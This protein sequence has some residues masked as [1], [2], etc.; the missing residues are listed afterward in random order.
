[1]HFNEPQHKYFK[2][3]IDEQNNFISAS[4]IV[5]LYETPYDSFYWSLYKAYEFLAWRELKGEHLTITDYLEKKPQEV[6]DYFRQYRISFK[7]KDYALFDHLR[8]YIDEN[9]A[10]KVQNYILKVWK[11]INKVSIIKGN[12]LHD[13]KEAEAL[14]LD[15]VTNPFTGNSIPVIKCNKWITSDTKV[16]TV[17]L[18]NLADGYYAELILDHDYKLGQSDKIWKEGNFFWIDDWKTNK[19]LNF[20]NGF[21]RMQYPVDHL[22]DCNWEHYKLQLSYYIHILEQYGY[23]CK[24]SRLTHCIY[25]E[26]TNIWTYKKYDFQHYTKEIANIL[27]DIEFKRYTNEQN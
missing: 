16:R 10:S 11:E 15:I 14:S 21:D 23:E 24:G 5:K 25:D 19:K 3:N 27:V 12:G 20:T 4:G 13:T 7:F 26:N 18:N 1:M 2:K 22:D 8:M 17:D 9:A 6:K